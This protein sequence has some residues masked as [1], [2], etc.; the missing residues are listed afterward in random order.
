MQENTGEN[1]A[2][3]QSGSNTVAADDHNKLKKVYLW[4]S[5]NTSESRQLDDFKYY[6]SDATTNLLHILELSESSIVA[7]VGLSGVGKS[8]AQVQVAKALNAK[9]AGETSQ[10][11]VVRRAVHFKW[12]GYLEANYERILQL[13]KMQGVTA[14][15]QEIIK[16]IADRLATSRNSKVVRRRLSDVFGDR[17]TEIDALD[18]MFDRADIGNLLANVVAKE[19]AIDVNDL[20]EKLL[21][22]SD[23]KSFSKELVISLVSQ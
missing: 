21:G 9:L 13:L 7:L 11:R 16:I 1:A 10:D 12:P 18:D 22:P 20:A 5:K 17:L 6:W 19:P 3:S 15:D 8:S 4:A 2:N 23:L 14:S